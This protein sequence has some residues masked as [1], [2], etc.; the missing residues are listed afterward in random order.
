MKRDKVGLKKH[1]QVIALLGIVTT[2]MNDGIELLA[3][4][5]DDH[6]L[7]ILARFLDGHPRKQI[8]RAK[9]YATRAVKKFIEM[10]RAKTNS[11]ASGF[12]LNLKQGEGLWAKRGKEKPSNDRQHQ[13]NVVEYIADHGKRGATV[14]LHANADRWLRAKRKKVRLSRKSPPRHGGSS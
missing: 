4:C 2:L 9:F 12:D 11:S 14:Y 7:H 3:L 1:L 8:G 10:E 13:L 5:L 6:H